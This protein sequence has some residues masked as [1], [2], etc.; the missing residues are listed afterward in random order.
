LKVDI[1]FAAEGITRRI[2]SCRS[3][4]VK[5]L[6]EQIKQSFTTLRA[7]MRRYEANIEIVDPQLKNNSE[8][9]EVLSLFET[10]WEKGNTYFLNSMR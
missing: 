9:V 4:A 6:A 10:N 7:L 8:L 5:A 1:L 2:S 3:R